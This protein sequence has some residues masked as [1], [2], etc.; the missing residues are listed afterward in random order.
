MVV[1]PG[2]SSTV[3]T[4]LRHEAA[5]SETAADVAVAGSFCGARASGAAA[6]AGAA[7]A[8]TLGA[9]AVGAAEE[10]GAATGSSMA[11]WGGIGNSGG[12]RIKSRGLGFWGMGRVVGRGG[13]SGE[14]VRERPSVSVEAEGEG[15]RTPDG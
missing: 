2:R 15:R 9:A 13:I 4:C 10:E 3:K 6:G 11:R 1:S 8:G 5:D 14:E 7:A 12:H